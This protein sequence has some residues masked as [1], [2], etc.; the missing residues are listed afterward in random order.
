LHDISSTRRV[1][2]HQR[3]SQSG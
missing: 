1:W 2:R 3:G